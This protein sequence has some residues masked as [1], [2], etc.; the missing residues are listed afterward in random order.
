MFY[1]SPKHRN[2]VEGGYKFHSQGGPLKIRYSSF[3]E[4]LVEF[5]LEGRTWMRPPPTHAVL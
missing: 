1:E 3:K 2:D 5:S 4:G